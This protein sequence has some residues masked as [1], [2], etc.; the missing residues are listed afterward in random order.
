MPAPKHTP[1]TWKQIRIA[2]EAGCTDE[3]LM[4]VYG[5]I[6]R[7]GIRARR[8]REKWLSPTRKEEIT[9][10]QLLQSKIARCN[11]ET[12]ATTMVSGAETAQKILAERGEKGSL[13]ASSILLKLLQ[14]AE[15]EPDRIRK[16][17]N[18]GDISTALAA[19]RKA[20]GMDRTEAGNASVAVN[21][22]MFSS[23]R[24]QT[25]QDVTPSNGSNL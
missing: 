2:Y 15:D 1:E 11:G 18:V 22:A 16:L 17:A 19:I 5:G 7:G 6:T 23:P 13:A 21:F 8:C 10:A 4:R 25:W 14:A 20:A 24:G 3:E 9:Q 12:N